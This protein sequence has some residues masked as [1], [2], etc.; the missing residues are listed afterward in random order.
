MT[1][2]IKYDMKCDIRVNVLTTIT[3]QLTNVFD[4]GRKKVQSCWLLIVTFTLD[5]FH[6]IADIYYSTV[7]ILNL[8]NDLIRYSHTCFV[9]V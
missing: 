3:V 5:I 9:K 1:L 4:S 6:H 8:S 7:H 2:D